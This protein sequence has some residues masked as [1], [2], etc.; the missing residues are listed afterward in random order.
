M[1]HSRRDFLVRTTCATL[2]AAAFQGTVRQFGLANL[3]AT[4]NAV[5]GNYRALVCIYLNGGSDSNNMI[6]PTDSTHYTAYAAARPGLAVP[7]VSVIPFTNRPSPG[8]DPGQTFGIHPNM[9]EVVNL[10]NANKLAVVTNVGPLVTPDDAGRVHGQ[11]QAEA[12][13]PLLA[14]RPGPGVAVGP[15]GH[16]DLDRLG[17]PRGRRR[18]RLQRGRR[19]VP[20]DHLDRGLVHVLHRPE[21]A[22]VDRN[23]VADERP[24]AQ[25]LQRVRHRRRAPVLDG[26]PPHDRRRGLHDERRRERHDAAGASTSARTFRPTRRSAPCSRTRGSR[27][28]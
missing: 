17:R 1:S 5:T 23:R 15:L 12:L 2:G 19:R 20:H 10:Y 13:R 9:P 21:A 18:R 24:R 26:L 25:R 4:P 27:T 3:L 7:L 16:Q 28:S 8:I 22:A 14:L 11:H 6:I